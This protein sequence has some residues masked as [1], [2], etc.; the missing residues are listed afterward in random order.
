MLRLS[1]LLECCVLSIQRSRL[2][3]PVEL[4]SR[5]VYFVKEKGFCSSGFAR[6]VALDTVLLISNQLNRAKWLSTV[7]EALKDDTLSSPQK[8]FYMEKLV[9]AELCGRQCQR[10][11]MAAPSLSK[12]LGSNPNRPVTM[13]DSPIKLDFSKYNKLVLVPY[14]FNHPAIDAIVAIKVP[15]KTQGRFHV[16]TYPIQITV[17]D[18]HKDSEYDFVAFQKSWEELNPRFKLVWKFVWICKESMRIEWEEDGVQKSE[19]LL[20]KQS[21]RRRSGPNG[22]A[23]K[24]RHCNINSF[25]PS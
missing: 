20:N 3:S 21:G 16:H 2:A 1:D 4:D 9:L 11:D 8:R 15:K 17:A 25:M 6:L 19:F 12:L 14:A 5:H 18:E 22:K 7:R 24:R 13:F 23:L 10:I